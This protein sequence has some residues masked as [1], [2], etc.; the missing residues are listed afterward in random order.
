[1]LIVSDNFSI[2]IDS[3]TPIKRVVN[4]LKEQLPNINS[5][6]LYCMNHLLL[7]ID[8]ENIFIT[9]EAN[10]D[11]NSFYDYIVPMNGVINLITDS[12]S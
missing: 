8:D 11:T 6:K 3:K 5:F 1:M 12:N 9:F 2:S 4:V 7:T 10:I